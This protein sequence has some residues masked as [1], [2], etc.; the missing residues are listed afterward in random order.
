MARDPLLLVHL[1][2]TAGTTLAQLL[3]YHYRDG[4][5]KGAGNV[6]SRFDEAEPRLEGIA[7]KPAIRAASGH[8]SFGLAERVLPE[9]TFV[10]ILREP[11]ARTLSQ[12]YFLVEV[13]R[14]GG[15]IPPG[16]DEDSRALSLEEAFDRGYL[17]D[18]LQTRMLC[19]LVSPY[20][21]LPADA[22]ERARAN[23]RDRFAYV[24]TTERFDELL[25][26][27][28][29]A[30]GWPTTAHEPARENTRRPKAVA[31]DLRAFAAGRNPLDRELYAYAGEL[32]A[33]KVDAA[34][35]AEAE[36][37]RAA[38]AQ[39]NRTDSAGEPVASPL[40]E[41][42]QRAL[43]EAARVRAAFEERN[44]RAKVKRARK[45]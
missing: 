12:Y 23:L 7:R 10:T 24:G 6:L 43:E 26:V 15:L 13:G 4:A 1:P 42:I 27:L 34:V 35:E 5:F 9:A 36:V 18:D 14:G 39:W 16:L 41:R 28:N 32:L 3:R 21:D 37:I 38:T 25:A 19:G 31:E 20:D 11:V 2:K 17:L 44:R 8:V 29:L 40:H 45:R 22:L 30:L 33:E